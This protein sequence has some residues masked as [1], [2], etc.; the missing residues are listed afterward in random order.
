MD[1]KTEPNVIEAQAQRK[2]PGKVIAAYSTGITGWSMLVNMISVILVYLYVPTEDSGLP[3]LV[4]QGALFGAVNV[5]ALITS[6]GR[7]LDALY[8]PLIA[9]KSDSSNHRQGRRIPFMKWAALPACIFCLLVF[10]PISG[11]ESG[12]NAAW[13]AITLVL[14]YVCATTYI[15]PYYAMLPE[16]AGDLQ[17]K[18]KLSTWQ[19]VGYVV[20]IGM[21]SNA[22][23]LT[24]YFQDTFGWEKLYCLQLTVALFCGLAALFMYIP[25]WFVNEREWCDGEAS[26]VKLMP[27][28]RRS[29]TNRNFR[30]YL[31]ADFAFNTSVTVIQAGLI[32]FVTILLQLPEEIGNKLMITLV[33]VSFLFYPLIG[34]VSRKFGLKPIISLSLILLG[35]VFVGVYF[36]GKADF[37]P[38]AQIYIVIC[39]AALPMATMNIV[40]LALLADIIERDSKATNT[41]NEALYF[42]VRYFFVKLAQTTG[43]AIFA[44]LLSYG[45]DVG[46]D[47][48]IRLSGLVG[49]GLCILAGVY[50]LRYKERRD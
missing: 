22:F 45:K 23:N 2:L 47:L 44:M 5:V 24:A 34:P 38:T 11:T 14:F 35:C 39:I 36:L 4:Y 8:D 19:S 20:G 25:V 29:L 31:F 42:A 7:L 21:A 1:D 40:P 9:K 33:G 13:L 6:G 48:G 30:L 27:A 18:V 26:S 32:Y 3:I 49:S 41:N 37:S 28:L 15:I 16:L 17:E 12:L 46:D 43:I 10:V 50:F